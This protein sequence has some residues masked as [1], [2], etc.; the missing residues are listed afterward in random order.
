MSGEVG[1]VSDGR[2]VRE[3]GG[4]RGGKRSRL[5]GSGAREIER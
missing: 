4:W 3:R 1:V 5:N 2:K